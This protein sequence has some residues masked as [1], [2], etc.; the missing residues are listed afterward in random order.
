MHSSFQCHN[1]NLFK[2]EDMSIEHYPADEHYLLITRESIVGKQVFKFSISSRLFRDRK[3]Q[4]PDG[5]G[6]PRSTNVKKNSKY[7]LFNDNI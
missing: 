5:R 3:I 2:R 7:I 1:V 6:A 4:P